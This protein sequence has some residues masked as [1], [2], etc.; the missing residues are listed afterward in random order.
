VSKILFRNKAY[1]E[2]IRSLRKIKNHSMEVAS[3]IESI[4]VY[5]GNF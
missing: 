5:E 1:D 3:M 4:E 2:A